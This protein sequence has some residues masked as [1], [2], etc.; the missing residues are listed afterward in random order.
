MLNRKPSPVETYNDL[1]GE[2]VN[3]FRV[4]RSKKGKLIEAVSFSPEGF[5]ELAEII[6]SKNK[7]AFKSAAH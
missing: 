4:L 1:D 6:V 2:V 5:S 7:Q 3:F